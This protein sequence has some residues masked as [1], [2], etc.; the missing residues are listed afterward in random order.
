MREEHDLLG[1]LEISECDYSGIH[2]KRAEENFAVSGYKIDEDFIKAYGIVK[3]ACIKTAFAIEKTDSAK[4]KAIFQACEEMADGKLNQYIK[5]DAFQGGAGTSLNMNVNEVIANRALEIMGEKKGNYE[6]ISPLNDINKFQSTN[7]TFPTAL[8]IAAIYKIRTLEE[9]VISLQEA[10]QKKE[11]DFYGL[12][13]I[14]R[15][16]LHE[17]VLTTLGKEFSAYAEAISRDRWRIYKCEERLRVVNLGGTAIGTG[18]GAPKKYI[19]EVVE[20]LRDLTSLGLARAENLVENTQNADVFSEVSGILKAH[21]SNLIK[22]V[23]DL[24]LLEAFDEI[25]LPAVQAGSSIMPGKVNPVIPE[26]V[27]QIG[28]KVI[29]NDVIISHASALGQLE[30]NQNMPLIAFTLLESLNMLINTNKIFT[31]KCINSITANEEGLKLKVNSSTA[32][33]TALLPK[34][35]Y[36]KLS[37]V[38]EK[39]KE[40][41][42]GVKEYILKENLMSEED[43][44][45]LISAENILAINEI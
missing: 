33:L 11:A 28:L 42:L 19:F 16:E 37:E 8:K 43:F 22:I 31:K 39:I 36:D 10:L 14:G 3:L 2:T 40:T 9:A 41:N 20:T 7:D 15:T 18:V 44:D 35:G 27:S 26:M 23:S 30:L 12:V 21:A 38:S 34:L 24:K 29:G 45:Y 17:A 13:K 5:V 1:K 25:Y 6:I 4:E 32:I